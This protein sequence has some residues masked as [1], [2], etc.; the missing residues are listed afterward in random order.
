VMRAIG[1]GSGSIRG[2]MIME[3][4][5]QGLFSFV[6]AVPLA[7]LLAQPLARVLGQTMLD[8]DLD[9]AFN[10]FAVLIWLAVVLVIAIFA[11]LLPARTA[12]RI[13]V[14]DSLAYG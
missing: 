10:S 14:R 9:F 12:T 8:I 1:A 5:L 7:Y 4:V 11:S 13:S 6:I 3:G 2:N